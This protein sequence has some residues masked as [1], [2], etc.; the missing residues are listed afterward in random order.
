MLGEGVLGEA[1]IDGAASEGPPADDYLV[2]P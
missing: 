2:R 1:V